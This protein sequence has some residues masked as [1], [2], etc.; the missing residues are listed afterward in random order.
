MK[1][2]LRKMEKQADHELVTKQND[3]ESLD[4]LFRKWGVPESQSLKDDLIDWKH[5]V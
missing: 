2:L 5:S 3:K 4:R 1:Q